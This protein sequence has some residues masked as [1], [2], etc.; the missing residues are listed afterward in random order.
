VDSP[1]A[2]DLLQTDHSRA[3]V[4]EPGAAAALAA[5]WSLPMAR[6]AQPGSLE[7]LGRVVQLVRLPKAHTIF[8]RGDL[9]SGLYYVVSGSVKLLAQAPAGREK[10]IDIFGDGQLFG[11]IG[12]FMDG[13][14]RSW[15]QTIGRCVLLYMPRN[16]VVEVI[17]HDLGL[18]LHFLREASN[19][20]QILIDA[21]TA[22]VS[23]PASGRV[24]AYLLDLSARSGGGERPR[25]IL[26]ATKSA[27][28]S[29]LSLS[30]EAL[31]RVLRRFHDNGLIEV[32]GR[33]IRLIDQRKLRACL[34]A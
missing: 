16:A 11:E 6:Y 19:R 2:L 33:G 24:A 5:L 32:S 20:A 34:D 18:A 15:A 9:P 27:I 13:P 22:I 28:A 4:G 1:F 14:Y 31:S 23:R 10:V 25:V 12:L 7:I 26:P 8:R 17:G 30:P 3:S 29:L 21:L